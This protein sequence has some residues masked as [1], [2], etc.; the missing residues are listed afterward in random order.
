MTGLTGFQAYG[1]DEERG[2]LPRPDPLQRLPAAFEAWEEA[3]ADLAKRLAAGT[4]RTAL[5]ELP[6]LDP[7]PLEG[8]AELERAMLLLSYFGHA[9]VW[10]APPPVSRLPANLAVPWHAVARRLGRPPVLSYA[11]YALHNWRRLDPAGPIALGNLALL[12]NFL[13]GLDEEWFILIHIEIEARAVPALRAIAPAQRAAGSDLP[14]EVE[15][16]VRVLA[17]ALTSMA[18]TLDRMP[19]GCDPYIYFRRVR[20]YIHGWKDHP[21]FPEGLVY[22]G[23]EEYAGRPQRFRGET[24][25]QTGIVPCLD[26]VLGI[27][28]REDALRHYLSE[29]REYMPPAHRRFLEA[30]EAG[31]SL[32]AY[33]SRVGGARPGLRS[34]YDACVEALHRFRATHLEYAGRY[35]QLQ[36]GRNPANPNEVG[37]GGTPFMRYLKKH[38]DET[39]E[40]RL[41]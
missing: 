39:A 13:A 21:A 32:R 15:R 4:I 11:S 40:H 28:H 8:G 25:A 41:G 33:V 36:A 27:R 5:L 22:E 37:T 24:G 1:L 12:Q 29:L 35:I 38:R 14:E 23:V 9:Y 20:P 17:Q 34:A 6:L 19:E 31:P 16:E 10:G 30:V 2:F 26:A 3:A 18:D 7:A